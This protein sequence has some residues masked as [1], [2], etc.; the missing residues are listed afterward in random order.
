MLSIYTPIGYI[1]K[2]PGRVYFGE[3]TGANMSFVQNT[4]PLE[5]LRVTK[6]KH[7]RH[8]SR[9]AFKPFEVK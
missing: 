1:V 6:S 8:I 4:N 2:Y 9:A 5:M 3:A 7:D